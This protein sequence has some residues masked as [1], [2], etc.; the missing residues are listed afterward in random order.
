MLT[1]QA[2]HQSEERYRLM[3]EKTGQMVY[4][5]NLETDEIVWS[6]AVLEITGIEER[7]FQSVNLKGWEERIHLTT[8]KRSRKSLKRA[9]VRELLLSPCIDSGARTA[10]ISML[11]MKAV[12]CLMLTE[13][14][15]VWSVFYATIPI[16]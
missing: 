3:A 15:C 14:R 12:F 10:V 6:G 2:L 9:S 11:R 5:L 16:R 13:L 4:D 8:V 1:E 7:E